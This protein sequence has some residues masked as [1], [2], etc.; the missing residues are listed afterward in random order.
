MQK[1]G[2][3][4]AAENSQQE[5]EASQQ[6]VVQ[7]QQTV[8]GWRK[9]YAALQADLQSSQAALQKEQRK[10]EALNEALASAGGG[11]SAMEAQLRQQ[12]EEAHAA[13]E[14][15][16]FLCMQGRMCGCVAASV[17][18]GSCAAPH[19]PHWLRRTNAQVCRQQGR[20]LGSPGGAEQ[21]DLTAAQQRCLEA[22]RR[23]AEAEEATRELQK[24]L[25]AVVDEA[26]R[27]EA[28]A[29]ELQAENK[30]LTNLVTVCGHSSVCS[31]F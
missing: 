14:R 9:D 16:E 19:A 8:A 18:L 20:S 26:E 3:I 29:M 5:L 31:V 23:A 25:T 21:H 12:L 17:P 4:A 11:S 1:M 27:Q 6:E 7:L 30:R 2:A 22:E 24:S 13:L 10:V 15:C 28:R